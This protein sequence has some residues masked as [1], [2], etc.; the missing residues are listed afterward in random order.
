[1]RQN[2]RCFLISTLIIL[3]SLTSC[4]SLLQ[5][6][7]T[8][9]YPDVWW[10]PVPPDQLAG[11]EVPPN[12][13]N[14]A[15]GEVILSKRNELGQLSNFAAASFTLDGDNYASIEGLWQAL[16]YPENA[17]DERLKDSSIVWPFTRAQ[18]MNMVAF[19]AKKAGE[20]ASSNMKKLGI[21]WVTYKG[22]KIFYSGI[23]QDKHYDVM[24]RAS[25]AKLENNPKIKSILMSTKTLKLL[26]DHKQPPDAPPAYHYYD[27]YMKLRAEFQTQE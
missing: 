22:Q 10:Q 23:D 19:D 15:A 11:W 14:R 20:A 21:K 9:S 2:F 1:M 3:S 12:A 24:L 4:A 6:S 7:S 13:A 16:K 17:D 8:D 27:I 5:N 26:P 25:R 18:V